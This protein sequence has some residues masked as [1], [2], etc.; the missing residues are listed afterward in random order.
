MTILRRIICRVK[1]HKR[2]KKCALTT[3]THNW[4]E[5]PRCH[6]V[7]SRKARKLLS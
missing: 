5:C 2:G 7:W 4:Y 3:P 6:T 1:G